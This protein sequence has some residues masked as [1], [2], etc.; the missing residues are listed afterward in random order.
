MFVE[1]LMMENQIVEELLLVGEMLMKDPPDGI[2][3][4]GEATGVGT[5]GGAAGGVA[6][7]G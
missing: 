2:A 7:G 6:N 4:V 5:S 1:K 3:A